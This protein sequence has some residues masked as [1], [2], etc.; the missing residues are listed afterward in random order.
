M[1]VSD[2]FTL[3]RARIRDNYKLE[4]PDEELIGYLNDAIS[5]WSSCSISNKDKLHVKTLIVNP[6][7]DVPDDFAK[8][9]GTFPVYIVEK[10]IISTEGNSVTCKYY[11]FDD[12]ISTIEDDLRFDKPEISILLQ[13][14][15]IYALNR[16]QFDVSTDTSLAKSLSDVVAQAKV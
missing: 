14:T 10:R 5:Y 11:A 8:F 12:H 16:N 13:L 4:Y 9:A 6:F 2:F 15:A 3:L 7:V 1:K